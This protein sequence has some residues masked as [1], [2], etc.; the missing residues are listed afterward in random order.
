MTD[1]DRDAVAILGC[2][3]IRPDRKLE[4]LPL[5]AEMGRGAV[6]AH[7]CPP[8]LGKGV[9]PSGVYRKVGRAQKMVLLAAHKALEEFPLSPSAQDQSAVCLGTGFGELGETLLFLENLVRLEEREP[10]PTR[11]ANSVH[12]SLASQVAINFGLKGENHTLTQGPI[13]FELALWQAAVLLQTGRAGHVLVCG[14]DELTPFLGFVGIECG[15]WGKDET[16][17]LQ[18]IDRTGHNHRPRPGEGAAAF[19]L[20][21]RSAVPAKGL[22]PC[23]HTIKVQPMELRQGQI[24][25]PMAEL[26]F[27]KDALAD[28]GVCLGDL[29]LIILG[30]N[31][32]GQLETLYQPILQLIFQAARKEI[33]VI[34]YKTL[35]GEFSTTPALG[36]GLA[37][38]ILRAGKIP[39]WVTLEKKP[40]PVLKNILMYQVSPLGFHSLCLVRI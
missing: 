36:L 7:L 28:T 9:I 11:F 38:D 20:G 8:S 16:P 32:P 18:E 24:I 21:L 12:N 19:V 15:F 2:G 33:G 4:L 35:W 29:D 10:K 27:V 13:S 26:K 3:S 34:S 22:L 31:C 14:V 6:Y 39:P 1:P 17:D 30:A 37:V 40:P 25:D 23:V 5:P